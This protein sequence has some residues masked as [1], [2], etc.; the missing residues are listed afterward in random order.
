MSKHYTAPMAIA[1]STPHIFGWRWGVEL[2]SNNKKVL[3]HWEEQNIK[4]SGH[5]KS[6]KNLKKYKKNCPFFTTDGRI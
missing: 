3:Y 2:R 5:W 4:K 6:L 1:L